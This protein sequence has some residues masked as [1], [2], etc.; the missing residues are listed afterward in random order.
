M[1]RDLRF[2]YTKFSHN[3]LTKYIQHKNEVNYKVKK[4]INT[5]QKKSFKLLGAYTLH[6]D[7]VKIITT[8]KQ[9]FSPLLLRAG[10]DF[11]LDGVVSSSESKSYKQV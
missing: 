5:K 10:A 7:T 9:Q 6:L 11:F 2:F 3:L 1:K 8:S 4:Y